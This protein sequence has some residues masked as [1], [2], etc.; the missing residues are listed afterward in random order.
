MLRRTAEQRWDSE[1]SAFDRVFQEE[2]A[3]RV[4]GRIAANPIFS[5]C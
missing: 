3:E 2:V 5:I 4:P 1:T